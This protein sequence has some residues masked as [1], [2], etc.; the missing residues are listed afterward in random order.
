[1][2]DKVLPNKL[3]KPCPFCGEELVPFMEGRF[4][5]HARDTRYKLCYA[6]TFC[7]WMDRESDIERWN[8]RAGEVNDE[9]SKKM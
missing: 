4:Y 5:A 1:M 7:I 8:M 6:N 9:F 3:L 2:N